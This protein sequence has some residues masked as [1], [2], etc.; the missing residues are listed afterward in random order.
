MVSDHIRHTRWGFFAFFPVSIIPGRG[1][2]A[3]F[4]SGD[5]GSYVPVDEACDVVYPLRDGAV[6][7]GVAGVSGDGSV[8]PAKAKN[9]QTPV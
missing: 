6:S 5:C 1:C 3:F 2:S 4:P 8:S 9:I 7:L